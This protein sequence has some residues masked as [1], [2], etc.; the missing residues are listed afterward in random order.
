MY[1][2]CLDLYVNIKIET[3]LPDFTLHRLKCTLNFTFKSTLYFASFQFNSIQINVKLF[4]IRWK[5][6]VFVL[7]V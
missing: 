2:V 7:T 6:C 3:Y 4:Q 1:N 5:S